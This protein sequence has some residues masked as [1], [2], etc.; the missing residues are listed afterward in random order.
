MTA[1]EFSVWLASLVNQGRLSDD[2]MRDALRQRANFDAVR[3]ALDTWTRPSVVGFCDDRML[4]DVSAVGLL[5][6]VVHL[7][8]GERQVY[9]ERVGPSELPQHPERAF[10]VAGETETN[11]NDDPAV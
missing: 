11:R 8:G 2:Q 6:Q 4:T 1:D 3:S 7:Y 10:R 5:S 9:F